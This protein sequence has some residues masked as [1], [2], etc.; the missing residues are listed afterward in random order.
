MIIPLRASTALW[1]GGPVAI[2]FV[3]WT[4]NGNGG[5]VAAP[6]WDDLVA[7]AGLGLGLALPLAA[8]IAAWES[9]RFLAHGTQKFPGMWMHSRARVM[10]GLAVPILGSVVLG[11]VLALFGLLIVNGVP[12]GAP[13]PA[14]PVAFLCM[15]AAATAAGMLAGRYLPRAIAATVSAVAVF[16][17]ATFPQMDGN[18]LSWRNITGFS[19]WDSAFSPY[20]VSDGRAVTAAS[21]LA[22]VL[23]VAFGAIASLRSGLRP[24]AA[25]AITLTAVAA[26][27]A[28]VTGAIG[29]AEGTKPYP[30]A[31]RSSDDLQCSEQYKTCL[32]PELTATSP[33]LGKTLSQWR[34]RLTSSGIEVPPQI[35][36]VAPESASMDTAA[37]HV[38]FANPPRTASYAASVYVYS[39]VWSDVCQGFVDNEEAEMV[40]ISATSGYSFALGI[41]AKDFAV[42]TQSPEPGIEPEQPITTIA[43]AK[44]AIASWNDYV[45]EQCL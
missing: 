25:S 29:V 26:I 33:Q 45:S 10:V 1:L 4:V 43:D 23:M 39:L 34:A 40:A 27:V 28:A 15:T 8:A 2:A 5:W 20:F 19:L 42:H 37:T 9:N 7:R 11:Y 41:S 17:W 16:S 13:S 3:V 38:F 32:W 24:L 18:N 44:N 30:Y 6:Y 21:I 36:S 35:T 14:V 22:L 12:T 31:H